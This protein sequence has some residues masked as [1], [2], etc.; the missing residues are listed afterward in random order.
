MQ[1][2]ATVLKDIRGRGDQAGL[3]SCNDCL[4]Q[5]SKVQKKYISLIVIM[6]TFVQTLKKWVITSAKYFGIFLFSRLGPA[7]SPSQMHTKHNRLVGG[8]H[9]QITSIFSYLSN[10][11]VTDFKLMVFGTTLSF[12]Y[13]GNLMWMPLRVI[14]NCLLWQLIFLQSFCQIFTDRRLS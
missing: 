13:Y 11:P 3:A 4:W 2:F 5:R 9:S 12:H 8:G 1:C 10:R 14:C 6:I 7:R